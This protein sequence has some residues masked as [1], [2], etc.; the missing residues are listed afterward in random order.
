MSTLQLGHSIGWFISCWGLRGTVSSRDSR[1]QG[2]LL[3][4]MS[5]PLGRWGFESTLFDPAN[6][7]S[8]RTELF[9]EPLVAAIEMV[10]AAHGG[11]AFRTEA[12]EHQ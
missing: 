1:T 11:L 9:F 7:S 3:R 5:E 6:V 12:R 10:D 4:E 2:T 8:E